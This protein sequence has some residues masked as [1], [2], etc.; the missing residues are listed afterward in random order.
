MKKYLF[1]GIAAIV[2]SAVLMLAFIIGGVVKIQSGPAATIERLENAINKKDLDKA[3]D[4]FG[5]TNE[6]GVFS[7]VNDLPYGGARVN[8]IPGETEEIDGDPNYIKMQ[9]GCVSKHDG[10]V[11]Y[12]IDTLRLY[13]VNGRWII[14]IF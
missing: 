4:C 6:W 9:V 13:K 5:A 8:L 7:S 1:T 14:E 10:K 2:I 11:E 12:E 3:L